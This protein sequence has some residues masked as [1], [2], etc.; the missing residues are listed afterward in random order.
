MRTD[1]ARALQL[2]RFAYALFIAAVSALTLASAKAL[3][4]QILAAVETLA[5]LA[6]LLPVLRRA[7][8]YALL[9][10]YAVAFALH[11]HAGEVAA[12]LLFYA[13]TA[14][15]LLQVQSEGGATLR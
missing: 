9:G 10:C 3:P 15:Y 8:L 12:N 5:A 1:P 11:L 6:L 7:G 13:A 14:L 2:F 4:V